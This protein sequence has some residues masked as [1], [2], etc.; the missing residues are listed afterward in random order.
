MGGA[1]AVAVLMMLFMLGF[2]ILYF[3]YGRPTES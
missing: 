2:M 1:S 3:R